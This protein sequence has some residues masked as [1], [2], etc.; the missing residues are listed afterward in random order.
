MRIR[1]FSS[2]SQSITAK[3]PS[4]N[5]PPNETAMVPAAVSAAAVS[6]SARMILRIVSPAFSPV[7]S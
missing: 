2:V 1:T 5:A 4:S 7:I 3:L 6:F